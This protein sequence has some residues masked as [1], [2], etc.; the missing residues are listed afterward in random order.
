M[1]GDGPGGLAPNVDV[2]VQMFFIEQPG[3]Q[4][5]VEVVAI[6]RDFIREIRNLGFEG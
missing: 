4:T 2:F 3:V 6:V 5:V 1:F